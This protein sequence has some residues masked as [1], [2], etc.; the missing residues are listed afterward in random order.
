M[1]DS[2]RLVE[3]EVGAARSTSR[4]EVFLA[5]LNGAVS[6][7]VSFVLGAILAAV[8]IFRNSSVED[9]VAPEKTLYNVVR[10]VVV[11]IKNGMNIFRDPPLEV[12]FEPMGRDFKKIRLVDGSESEVFDRLQVFW[13]RGGTKKTILDAHDISVVKGAAL[14]RDPESNCQ[15]IFDWITTNDLTDEDKG[16]RKTVLLIRHDKSKPDGQSCSFP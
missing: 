11:D 14:G 9:A 6:A 5:S 1:D 15:F 3:I 10:V 4:R 2:G 13:I 7:T 8:L 12:V 16:E